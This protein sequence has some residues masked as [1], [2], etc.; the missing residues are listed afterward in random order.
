MAARIL[1]EVEY[2]RECLDYNPETGEFQWRLRPFTHF[3]KPETANMWNGKWAGKRAGAS[4]SLGYRQICIN[5]VLYGAHRLAWVLMKGDSF[6]MLEID[7]ING[8][9][10]DN[11]INNLRLL[12]R[13]A[14]NAN[15]PRHRGDETGVRGIIRRPEGRFAV[16]ITTR[17]PRRWLGTFDTIDEAFSAR[18]EFLRS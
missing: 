12:T 17:G 15:T 5:R 16:F 2:L 10:G 18:Q 13:T 6:S 14:N 7:H 4:D 1:P 9:P 3:R 8:D 11:R